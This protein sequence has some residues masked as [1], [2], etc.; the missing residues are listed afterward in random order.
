MCVAVLSD[1]AQSDLGQLHAVSP[2]V[3]DVTVPSLG[4][5]WEMMCPCLPQSAFDLLGCPHSMGKTGSV[6][7]A[8]LPLGKICCCGLCAVRSLDPVWW[9]DLATGRHGSVL[10]VPP[11]CCQ[12]V[13]CCSFP[14][15]GEIPFLW[16]FPLSWRDMPILAL[17]S[18]CVTTCKPHMELSFP[19]PPP[20]RGLVPRVSLLSPR[21]CQPV[22]WDPFPKQP[23]RAPVGVSLWAPCSPP[24]LL[25]ANP[26]LH[27]HALGV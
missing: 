5:R 27:T 13:L 26:C 6:S 10:A 12:L 25:R 4:C 16:E 22:Q 1:R 17:Y 9:Q 7:T 11:T 3:G 15:Q 20:G 2:P 19:E 14:I 21:E 8:V 24:R 18:P 23:A